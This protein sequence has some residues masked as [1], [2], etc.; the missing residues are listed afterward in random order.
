M[1]NMQDSDYQWF[2][3]NYSSIFQQ[4]GNAYVAIKDRKIL[5]VYDSYATGIAETSRAEP[6]GSFIVQ[7]CNGHESGYTNYI[8]SMNFS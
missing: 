1:S 2:L 5:G 7:Y 6:L 4:Y 3:E 8:S